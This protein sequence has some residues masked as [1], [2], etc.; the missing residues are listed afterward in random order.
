MKVPSPA[1]IR[2]TDDHKVKADSVLGDAVPEL[3][4]VRAHGDAR[5]RATITRCVRSRD[6][7]CL[8]PDWG[9]TTIRSTPPPS[10]WTGSKCPRPAGAFSR[11]PEEGPSSYSPISA[12]TTSHPNRMGA[13]LDGMALNGGRC[14][15]EGLRDARGPLRVHGAP[16]ELCLAGGPKVR[17]RLPPASNVRAIL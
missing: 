8:Y 13:R 15:A 11:P 17:I 5:K 16:T 3:A 7:L 9:N 10:S 12:Q 1:R 6:L 14:C 2:H 4:S